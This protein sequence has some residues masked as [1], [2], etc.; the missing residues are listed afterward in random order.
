ME[1]NAP[2][3]RSATIA[4][5]PG[6]SVGAGGRDPP[7]SPS[8]D[9]HRRLDADVLQPRHPG[10]AA[11]STQPAH[12]GGGRAAAR[13]AA[14]VPPSG[15]SIVR[16]SSATWIVHPDQPLPRGR[17]GLW[18]ASGGIRGGVSAG[19]RWSAAGPTAPVRCR[20]WPRSTGCCQG[21]SSSG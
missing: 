19:W 3:T 1:K 17:P 7:W 2:S 9:P 13:A 12:P 5:C 8:R 6:R 10:A 16:V 20:R 4:P 21:R 15:R 11:H 18:I 14:R